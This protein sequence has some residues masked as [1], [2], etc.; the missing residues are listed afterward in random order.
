M[1]INNSLLLAV[2]AVQ[3]SSLPFASATMC[4]H[5]LD[6]YGCGIGY[7]E[8]G[9]FT[10][11]SGSNCKCCCKQEDGGGYHMETCDG[12]SSFTQT[13]KGCGACMGERSCNGASMTKIGDKSCVHHRSCYIIM[14]S[15]IKQYS[16]R[17]E[18]ACANM[19]S[20]WVGTHSCGIGSD[21][22]DACNSIT[23]SNIGDNSCQK[24]ESCYA[25]RDVYDPDLT[26]GQY[27]TIGNNACNMDSVCKHC[28]NDSV[29]PDNACNGDKP[30]TT[31]SVCNYCRVSTIVVAT[32]FA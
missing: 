30:D 27:L 29:V 17:S 3:L 13:A 16:C 32:L 4:K 7:Y 12:N 15:Y 8:A 26:Q 14:Y 18:K 24:Y 19:L 22:T 5:S 1:R 21:N 20:S 2:T 11:P 25:Q 6:Y 10:E 23:Y 28:E 9:Y 31:N